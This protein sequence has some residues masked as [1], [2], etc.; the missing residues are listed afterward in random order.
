[1][2]SWISGQRRNFKAGRLS[3]D[4]IELLERI[5]MVWDGPSETW[6][7]MYKLEHQYYEENSTVSISST[8]FTYKN[9]SL[10]SWIATQRKN[11]SQGILTDKQVTLLNEIGMEWV[12]TNNPD[13]VWEKNYNT[14]LD[15]YSKY[16]HLYLPG[17]PVFSAKAPSPSL[18][19]NGSS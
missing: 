1:M 13:Y 7:E 17:V 2:G 11:Y 18:F 8:S 5:S 19:T 12:Y 4:K 16:K 3:A 10:G 14:V 15:F 6:K 9:A